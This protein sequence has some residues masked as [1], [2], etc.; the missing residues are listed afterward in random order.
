MAP[1]WIEL[2]TGSFEDKK[3]WRSYKSRVRQL[4]QSHRTAVEG[5]ERYLMYA[6]P[7]SGNE[8]LEMFDDLVDLF[9]RSAAAGTPVHAIVGDDPVEFAESFKI[10]YTRSSWLD[11]EKRRLTAAVVR[12]ESE[13]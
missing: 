4:P 12:A 1:R 2:I 6:G 10:N 5:V 13:Q 11:K 3:R 8:L 7:G 9:E